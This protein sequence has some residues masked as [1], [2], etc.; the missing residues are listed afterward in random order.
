[1]SAILPFVVMLIV[2]CTC[3]RFYDLLERRFPLLKFKRPDKKQMSAR[4]YAKEQIYDEFRSLFLGIT[5]LGAC[6]FSVWSVFV[7][8]LTETDPAMLFKAILYMFG[9]VGAF[10]GVKLIFYG[11]CLLNT[12]IIK[13]DLGD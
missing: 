11:A 5:F 1:M 13:S 8:G 7:L 9:M 10:V 2:Y 3:F 6:V 4:T 12:Y